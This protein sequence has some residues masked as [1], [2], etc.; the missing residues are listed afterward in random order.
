MHR[1]TSS[2]RRVQDVKSSQIRALC[3][4]NTGLLNPPK[5]S[6]LTRLFSTNTP[7]LA[8]SPTSKRSVDVFLPQR[9][10]ETALKPLLNTITVKPNSEHYNLPSFLSYH[11]HRRATTTDPIKRAKL[12]K[13]SVYLGTRYEYLIQRHLQDHLGFDLTRV[14]GKG[15]G[16]IDLIGT[17]T[18]PSSS[19]LA[20][21]SGNSANGGVT[22]LSSKP[23]FRILLQA[24]RLTNTRKPMPALMR[25]LEGTIISSFSSRAL[26]E[27]FAAHRIRRSPYLPDN[28]SV[29]ASESSPSAVSRN[30]ED[31][32]EAEAEIL[33]KADLSHLPTLGILLT[34]RPLTDGIEKAMSTS[35]R[36]LMYIYLG[37]SSC[38]PP[39]TASAAN[40]DGEE[41]SD[42]EKSSESDGDSVLPNEVDSV[43]RD[44]D[45][46]VPVTTVRQIAWNNAAS[47][48]GLEGYNV[49][50]KYSDHK[51]VRGGLDGEA[52]IVYQ[53]R[54]VTFEKQMP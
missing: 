32:V 44:D 39:G 11:A 7:H 42:I 15:D 26:Q 35:R 48:A 27:A 37:E 18:L 33:E 46:A 29:G 8:P 36:P 5:P 47:R 49:V 14:G 25:E 51:V 2:L 6:Q 10:T 9:E 54:P 40:S 22:K 38:P 34:T 53:G 52:V 3:A 50:R 43:V 16:G 13:S 28:V 30:D 23:T 41:A 4:Y 24:K 20:I 1:I 45:Q 21:A 19:A 12:S 17:W 31:D